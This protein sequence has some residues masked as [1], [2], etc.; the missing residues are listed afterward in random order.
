MENDFEGIEFHNPYE[1]EPEKTGEIKKMEKPVLETIKEEIEPKNE[2]INVEP[3][4]ENVTAQLGLE[5]DYPTQDNIFNNSDMKMNNSLNNFD[6]NTSGNIVNNSINNNFGNNSNNNLNNNNNNNYNFGNNYNN[7]NYNNFNNNNNTNVNKNNYNNNN[8]NNYN[9]YNGNNNYNNN[10]TYNNFNN[11]N[12]SNYN[13]NNN[14]NNNFNNNNNYNNFNVNSSYN[15]FNNNNNNNNFNNNI[16][17]NNSVNF[18][19]NSN[20]NYNNVNNNNQ[21]N[22]NNNNNFNNNSSNYNNNNNN[23]NNINSSINNS[24]NNSVFDNK[25]N[26]NSYIGDNNNNNFENESKINPESISKQEDNN[27]SN[28]QNS[29]DQ[30]KKT[31]ENIIKACDLK[32]KNAINMFKNYQIKEAKKN[33]SYLISYLSTL[34][35]TVKEK[36]TFAISLIPDITSLKNNIEKKLHE[37]NYF[38]YILNQTLFKNIQPQRNFDIVKYAEN[39]IIP[40]PYIT[41]EDIYDTTLDPNKPTK[42]V[43]L[44]YYSEAQRTGYKTLYLYGPNG[45][46]KTLYVHALANELG[47]VLGQLDNLQNLKIQYLV[48]EFSRLITEYNRPIIVYVKNIDLMSREALGEILFLHDKFNSLDRKVLFIGS[49]PYPLRNLP[50]QLKFKYIHL[51]NSA[52]QSQKYNI[53]KFYFE[54]FGIKLNMSESDF[55]NFAY[56]NFKNFSNRDIFNVIKF[57]MDIKKQIGESIFDVGRTELENAM[58]AKPGT[59]DPQSI[60]FYY[61]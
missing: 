5:F 8:Y 11:N 29:E 43:L 27:I 10:N 55:A 39:F 1:D 57:M 22:Y 41:F 3:S 21:N 14:N 2:N 37:Y 7:Y 60:Q 26:N 59:L 52:N 61:L 16:N 35:K 36:N 9:N 19:N 56:Q 15:N 48:K 4:N 33:I 6:N 18:N 54:K 51:I 32:Y 34:A 31:I 47:A 53:F 40:R 44:E 28:N 30:N 49:S 25:I 13:N 12:Y 20:N 42:N 24:F 50:P 38:T 58:K 23:F 17:N 45:S 46:G